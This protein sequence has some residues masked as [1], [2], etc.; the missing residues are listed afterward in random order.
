MISRHV[1]RERCIEYLFPFEVRDNL[2][3]TMME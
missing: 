3:A 2:G 1:L